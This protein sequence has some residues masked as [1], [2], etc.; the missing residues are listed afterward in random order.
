[1]SDAVSRSTLI[2]QARAEGKWLYARFHDIWLSPD[3]LEKENTEGNFLWDTEAFTLCDPNER[4]RQIALKIGALEIE[5]TRLLIQM[6][7]VKG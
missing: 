3:Q 5:R 1:M 6:A 7:G 2:A 4:L